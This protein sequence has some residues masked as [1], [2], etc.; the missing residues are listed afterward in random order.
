MRWLKSTMYVK[1]VLE[2]KGGINMRRNEG[3]FLS[4]MNFIVLLLAIVL[5]V[6]MFMG[7][8]A[9]QIFFGLIALT[10]CVLLIIPSRATRERKRMEQQHQDKQEGRG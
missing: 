3:E 9:V 2:V 5:A 1:M 10:I 7:S 8:S 6:I 4:V